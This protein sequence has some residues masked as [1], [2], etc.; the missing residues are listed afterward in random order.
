MRKNESEKVSDALS[1]LGLKLMTVDASQTFYKYS[2][3]VKN[4]VQTKPLDECINP[5][6][7]RKIIGDAFMHVAEAEIKKLNLDPSQVFL[8][9][10]TLRPGTILFHYVHVDTLQP[11]IIC[12]QSVMALQTL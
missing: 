1:K 5:E 12:R 10:G 2:T 9:Q 4:Q 3:T 6:E 11:V 7:K 8:A